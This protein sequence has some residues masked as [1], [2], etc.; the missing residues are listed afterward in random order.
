MVEEASLKVQQLITVHALHNEHHINKMT[1]R[2][3]CQTPNPPRIPVF[4]TQTNLR[5]GSI[6]VSLDETF[7]REGRNEK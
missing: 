3:L 5:S 4:Y 1:E 2:W 6:F 7:R